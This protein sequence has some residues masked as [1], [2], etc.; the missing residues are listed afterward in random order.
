M[1]IAIVLCSILTGGLSAGTAALM[2]ETGF[3]G[4]LLAY[5]LGG[6]SGAFVLILWAAL[7]PESDTCPAPL[8]VRA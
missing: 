3:L 2:L 5:W 1:A 8:P 6:M 4:S 7:R